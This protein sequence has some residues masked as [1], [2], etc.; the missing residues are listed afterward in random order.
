MAKS[1]REQLGRRMRAAD[2][3]RQLVFG[4]PEAE[5]AFA[6]N[7]LL[8]QQLMTQGAPQALA[9]ARTEA[10]N[11]LQQNLDRGQDQQQFAMNLA[12]QQAEERNRVAADRE[13]QRLA[14]AEAA[15]RAGLDQQRIDQAASEFSETMDYQRGQDEVANQLARDRF[16]SDAYG[17]AVDATFKEQQLAAQ[18][19]RDADARSSDERRQAFAEEQA[20]LDN[21]YRQEQASL[22]DA[23]RN[24]VAD[25]GQMMD[26]SNLGMRQQQF[27]STQE[28]DREKLQQEATQFA[29]QLSLNERTLEEGSAS[30]QLTQNINT[31]KMA[32]QLLA[33]ARNMD[34]TDE[35]Q[36]ELAKLSSA[37]RQI[38][39]QQVDMRPSQYNSLMQ[40][41]AS[42]FE[43][44][45]ISQYQN[46]S[47]EFLPSFS[48]RFQTYTDPTTNLQYEVYRTKDGEFQFNRI[49]TE[50]GSTSS[51]AK[52][53]KN[54]QE[55]LEDVA[56]DPKRMSALD[57]QIRDNLADDGV[58][59]TPENYAE[60][61]RSIAD[62][63]LLSQEGFGQAY[64]N[65]DGPIYKLP[66]P[67]TQETDT[68][69]RQL[70]PSPEAGARTPTYSD[71]ARSQQFSPGSKWFRGIFGGGAPTT[72]A[73]RLDNTD[74]DLS[75]H[76]ARKLNQ[77]AFTKQD[78]EKREQVLAD[79]KDAFF[80]SPEYKKLKSY[81]DKGVSGGPL[82]DI[83]R[84]LDINAV[85]KI[86][87]LGID[88][89]LEK[90]AQ[91]MIEAIENGED[92]IA[93][94]GMGGGYLS[95][96]NLPVFPRESLEASG[97]RAEDLPDVFMDEYGK[98]Y[99]KRIPRAPKPREFQYGID[100][101]I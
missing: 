81:A 36:R 68:K 34:L 18:L 54:R 33:D 29:Q 66:I 19:Q 53:Y 88:K 65:P 4:G 98:I 55:F 84:I 45:N 85:T 92:H 41:W 15:S 91:G 17:R 90:L 79:G 76:N 70:Y 64:G 93:Y 74:N 94:N 99:R 26:L 16:Q 101:S 80:S 37:Y 67:A 42:N 82:I 2:G 10:A 31:G 97:M 14:V 8:Q 87:R 9:A 75:F 32:E 21:R 13:R 24:R 46:V 28:F 62:Q 39:K 52:F 48:E 35:G 30:R 5:K 38:A 71:R 1:L 89:P 20:A 43:K 73:R 50:S 56:Q 69:Q 96:M 7:Q 11:L 47:E 40:D 23:Y 27:Q 77:T 3:S 72:K 86:V 6:A 57:K 44:A 12:Q 49:N 95:S 63:A 83:T 60:A 78:I 51:G 58:E 100:P 61:A 25:F 59:L 22:D